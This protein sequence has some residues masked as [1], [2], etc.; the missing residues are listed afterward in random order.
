M[1]PWF[2]NLQRFY[3][4]AEGYIYF[5]G[6]P[7]LWAVVSHPVTQFCVSLTYIRYP[8]AQAGSLLG[9]MKVENKKRAVMYSASKF[10]IMKS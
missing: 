7:P 5:S 6:N 3:C 9:L 8:V 4:P 2:Y 1:K 10:L